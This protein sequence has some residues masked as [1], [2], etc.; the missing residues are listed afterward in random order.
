MQ[1][2]KNNF[3]LFFYALILVSKQVNELTSMDDKLSHEEISAEVSSNKKLKNICS[4]DIEQ[5]DASCLV[6]FI[7]CGDTKDWNKLKNPLVLAKNNS[8]FTLDYDNHM[9]F[10]DYTRQITKRLNDVN[11]YMKSTDIINLVQEKKLGKNGYSIYY[12]KYVRNLDI[13]MNAYV[14]YKHK[15]HQNKY[16]WNHPT[17]YNPNSCDYYEVSYYDPSSRKLVRK[18]ISKDEYGN[19]KRKHWRQI[20]DMKFSLNSTRVFR[21]RSSQ[22]KPSASYEALAKNRGKIEFSSYRAEHPLLNKLYVNSVDNLTDLGSLNRTVDVSKPN[23]T[24]PVVTKISR[25]NTNDEIKFFYNFDTDKINELNI[26]FKKFTS[27][28]D[29]ILCYAIIQD[30]F[31]HE[32]YMHIKSK[33]GKYYL[34]VLSSLNQFENKFFFKFKKTNMLTIRMR[35]VELWNIIRYEVFIPYPIC[36]VVGENAEQSLPASAYLN[37]DRF[38]EKDFYLELYQRGMCFFL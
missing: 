20:E 37:C 38:D 10:L 14:S 11:R 34:N 29:S 25:L 1:L 36:N 26:L 19:F 28:E 12:L 2:N 32:I 6:T 5:L 7:P 30:K 15:Y 8:L 22:P 9:K 24:K 31:T 16:N 35:S 3:S 4:H 18:Q 17:D 27:Y 13:D 33:A 23:K 21:V